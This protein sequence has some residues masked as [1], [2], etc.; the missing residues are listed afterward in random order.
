MLNNAFTIAVDTLFPPNKETLSFEN[1][2]E[3]IY[4][5]FNRPAE[6][7]QPASDGESSA[8]EDGN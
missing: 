7:I 1:R 3:L 4:Q 2:F 8:S 6:Q 5:E